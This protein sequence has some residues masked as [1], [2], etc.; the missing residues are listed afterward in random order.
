MALQKT[1]TDHNGQEYPDAYHVIH[2]LRIERINSDGII[3][4][5]EK[6]YYVCIDVAVYPSLEYKDKNYPE[7]VVF[8]ADLRA[9]LNEFPT[10]FLFYIEDFEAL[11]PN[12][13]KYAYDSLKSKPF[14]EGAIDV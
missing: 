13:V 7:L 11:P 1:F 5:T 10:N 2:G 8:R 14:Y 6:G 9:I 12:F 3:P 4:G